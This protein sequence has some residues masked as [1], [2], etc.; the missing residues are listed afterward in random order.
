VSF[1]AK[2]FHPPLPLIKPTELKGE[3]F[4]GDIYKKKDVRSLGGR[5]LSS[6]DSLVK[7]R[8]DFSDADVRTFSAKN[9]GF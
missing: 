1:G 7:R 3:K 4:R 9:S 8:G 5:A 6:A 2:I